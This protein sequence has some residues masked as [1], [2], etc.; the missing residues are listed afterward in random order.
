[1]STYA[2]HRALLTIPTLFLVSVLVFVVVRVMPGDVTTVLLQNV[3][4]SRQDATQLR[5]RLGIDRPVYVQY[6]DWVGGAL[7]GNLGRSLLNGQPIVDRVGQALPVTLELAL[8]ALLMSLV[9]AL[10]VGVLAALYQD[11]WPDYLVRGIAVLAAAL[12]GFWVA[13]VFLVIMGRFA[14]WAPDFQ[15]H[16]LWQAPLANLAQFAIPAFILGLASSAGLLRL[17]R[18]LLLEVLRQDYVRTAYAKGLRQ[19]TVV[20]SHALINALMP[21]V[22]LIG[23]H[24]AALLG[25]TITIEVIFGLPGV[26]RAMIDAVTNRD[27]PTIQA[28]NLILACAVVLINLGVDLTYGFLDPRTRVARRG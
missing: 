23:L 9:V 19:R 22:T 11:R 24:L 16:P 6:V 4:Y 5:E 12:P 25:G 1:M 17:T 20:I 10:P 15:Y 14:G 18:G 7:R 21:V 26:G 28:L 13:T 27:Y 8:L 2:I 3:A